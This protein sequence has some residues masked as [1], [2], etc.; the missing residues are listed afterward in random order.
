MIYEFTVMILKYY[1]CFIIY[2]FYF[3]YLVSS[4][5]FI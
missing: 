2:M 3:M 5:M 1:N 4:K